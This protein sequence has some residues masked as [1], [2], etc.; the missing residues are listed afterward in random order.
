MKTEPA[1]EIAPDHWIKIPLYAQ[2]GQTQVPDDV[3]Q[4]NAHAEKQINAH[5]DNFIKV[6]LESLF[7]DEEIGF[8]ML[9]H[10][11]QPEAYIPALID[12][13]DPAKLKLT[14]RNDM[15]P[16]IILPSNYHPDNKRQKG[17]NRHTGHELKMHY[18]DR[19]LG[20]MTIEYKHDGRIAIDITTPKVAPNP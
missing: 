10:A 15:S 13:L 4:H 12:K 5:K 9:Q 19:W 6:C 16:T 18:D 7:D 2:P 3:R 20:S 17:V 8:A 14:L 1:N 11:N